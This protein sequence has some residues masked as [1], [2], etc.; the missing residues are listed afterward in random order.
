MEMASCFLSG[1]GAV[2]SRADSVTLE[3]TDTYAIYSGCIEFVVKPEALD[4]NSESV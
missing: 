1:H 3:K 4:R 2:Q